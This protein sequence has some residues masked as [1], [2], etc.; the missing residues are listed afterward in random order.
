[1]CIDSSHLHTHGTVLTSMK[2]APMTTASVQDMV[3]A[4]RLMA[5]SGNHVHVL[6]VLPSQLV[7][8]DG[9]TFL[10]LIHIVVRDL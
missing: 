3:P 9:R 4:C 2:T 6:A 8:Q 1:M 10:I 5:G 7:S